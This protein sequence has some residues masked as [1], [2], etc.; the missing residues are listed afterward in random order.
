[1]INKRLIFDPIYDNIELPIKLF[2]IIDTP[3]FQRLKSIKQLGN[4][5]NIYPCATNTRFS[6]CIGTSYISREWVMILKENQPELEIKNWHIDVCGIAGLLHDIGHGPFSHMFEKWIHS[7]NV[8]WNHEEFG[9]RYINHIIDVNNIDIENDILSSAK[10]LILG[11]PPNNE[12][13]WMKD[14][15]A[16]HNT[17]VD[18]DKFDYLSRD[19]YHL[20]I[21]IDFNPW[22]LMKNSRIINDKMSFNHK[23]ALDIEKMFRARYDLHKCAYSHRLVSIIDLMVCDIIDKSNHVFKFD[24]WATDFDRFHHLTD[25]IIYLIEMTD[26][27][28]LLESQRLISRIARRD[29]YCTVGELVIS[30]GGLIDKIKKLQPS[31]VSSFSS[32]LNPEDVRISIRKMNYALD[33]CD[34][35]ERI[36]FFSKKRINDDFRIG[37]YN[38]SNLRPRV[39]QEF[40]FQIVVTDRSKRSEGVLAFEKLK[41]AYG[42]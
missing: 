30:E 42:M 12:N 28:S 22:R 15:V 7:R 1:M 25:N 6:H 14:I 24:E 16:N 40:L 34:P 27:P 11:N 3:Q 21:N 33:D 39:F 26:D 23:V 8:E 29:F 31:D 37:A 17:S 4:T 20:G 36:S 35:M 9:T 10:N 18:S 19:S 13:E 2:D 41:R 38:I 32:S 5:H